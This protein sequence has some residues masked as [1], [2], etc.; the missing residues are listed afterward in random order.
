LGHDAGDGAASAAF[1][2][3]ARASPASSVDMDVATARCRLLIAVPA[4]NSRSQ[5]PDYRFLFLSQDSVFKTM[6]ADWSLISIPNRLD[7]FHA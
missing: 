2:P 6:L 7:V 4:L 3:S 1:R 5:D